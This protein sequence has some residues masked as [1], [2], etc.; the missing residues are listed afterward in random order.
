MDALKRT[1][2]SRVAD[3]L[4]VV[5]KRFEF[6]LDTMQKVKVNDPCEF[7]TELD[8]SEY[9]G[10]GV[11]RGQSEA[12]YFTLPCSPCSISA[13]ATRGLFFPFRA[14]PFCCSFVA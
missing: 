5:L 6:N 1:R 13:T 8:V 12:L 9:V 11:G 4:V 3:T 2:I 14:Q 10:D 7:P